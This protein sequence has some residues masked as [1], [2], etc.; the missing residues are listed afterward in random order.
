MSKVHKSNYF[1]GDGMSEILEK[2]IS[3]CQEYPLAFCKFIS[4][5]DVGATG[6]HQA[7]LY[8][9]KNSYQILFDSAGNKGANK[10]RFVKIKWQDSFET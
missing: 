7:G 10:E 1:G 3:I 9:P 2:T 8:I 6:T 5:N 4:A